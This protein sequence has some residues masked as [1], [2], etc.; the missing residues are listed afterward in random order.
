MIYL[1]KKKK[2][3]ANIGNFTQVDTLIFMND[4]NDKG[5]IDDNNEFNF[6]KFSTHLSCMKNKKRAPA[7]INALKLKSCQQ[8]NNS[9]ITINKSRQKVHLMDVNKFI[10][11]EAAHST[12]SSIPESIS[13]SKSISIVPIEGSLTKY[14]N[15]QQGYTSFCK[16]CTK[17]NGSNTEDPRG[18]FIKK[19]TKYKYQGYIDVRNNSKEGFGKVI[20]KDQSILLSYFTNNSADGISYFNDKPSESEFSGTYI[21]N[22]PNGYGLYKSQ[23]AIL[24]GEW[25]NSSMSNIGREYSDNDTYYQGD[26]EN[27]I[28][29]GIGLYRWSDGTI[30]K[31]E[32]KNNQMTGFGLVIYNDDK[33]YA[34]EM[35]ND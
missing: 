16:G 20:W 27:C 5:D 4:D 32:W 11:N 10:R 30:Y 13:A 33:I 18:Y 9:L 2:T 28:K 3:I 35:I 12:M 22:R 24:E 21:N 8:I 25:M 1:K 7:L 6:V 23:G 14:I 17:T 15:G 26:F 34:G 29:Q 31:G 19:K